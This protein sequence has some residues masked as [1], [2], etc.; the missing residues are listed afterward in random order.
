MIILDYYYNIIKTII[1]DKNCKSFND[2]LV[3]KRAKQ[4]MFVYNNMYL[5]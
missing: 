4:P 3:N 1:G 2:K 5:K